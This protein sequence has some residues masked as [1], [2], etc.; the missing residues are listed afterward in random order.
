MLYP[1]NKYLVVNPI[2]ETKTNTGIL[3]PE[4][5]NIE[6]NAFKLVEVLE[7]HANSELRRG[8]KILVPSHMIEE[9]TFSGKTYYLVTEN[10]VVGF[11]SEQDL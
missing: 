10:N 7:P 8:M 11:Y 2:E 1:L 6:N 5:S 3:V 9:A 4:G